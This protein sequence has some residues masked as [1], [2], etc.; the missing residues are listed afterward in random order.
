MDFQR[1]ENKSEDRDLRVSAMWE[2]CVIC[3]M[4]TIFIPS[5]NNN[6][7]TH[8][9]NEKLDPSHGVHLNWCGKQM[10]TKKYKAK[11]ILISNVIVHTS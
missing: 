1:E 6:G 3:L 5:D 7:Y 2:Y 9:M 4:E 10:Q 11:S 8:F